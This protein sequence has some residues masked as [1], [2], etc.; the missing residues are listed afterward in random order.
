MYQASVRN[1]GAWDGTMRSDWNFDT[2]KSTTSAMGTFRSMAKDFAGT[3]LSEEDEEYASENEGHGSIDT[4][5]ATKG[6]DPMVTGGLGMNSQAAHST[7]IIRNPPSPASEQDIPTLLAASDASSGEISGSPETPPLGAPPAYSGSMR[8][9]RRSS[10]AARHSVNGAGTVVREADLGNGI[11]T[12]RPVKK[13]DTV[14]SLRL[15]AEHVG[16]IRREESGSAPS[17]PT[18]HK[19]AASEAGKAGRAIVDD[20]VLPILQNVS[21]RHFCKTLPLTQVSPGYP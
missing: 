5:A 10:Y 20:V 17:S 18:I 19:R 8:S 13:V 4:G 3:S 12:I 1:S 16:S 7:V 14:G 9:S 15:S 21:Q 6:S 2:I 11:D